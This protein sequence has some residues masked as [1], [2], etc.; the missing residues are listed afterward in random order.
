MQS[1]KMTK[2][3]KT[4][5][6]TEFFEMID[7]TQPIRCAY[8]LINWQVVLLPCSDFQVPSDARQTRRRCFD[9]SWARVALQ[10]ID[11]SESRKERKAGPIR[12][13][14]RKL[15]GKLL[16]GDWVTTLDLHIWLTQQT[17]RNA[18]TDTEHQNVSVC[19]IWLAR[20]NFCGAIAMCSIL[21]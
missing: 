13:Q 11:Q 12:S 2:L 10:F 18:D 3:L 20:S 1:S 21:T 5:S 8:Q 14:E 16:A 9:F 6:Y 15:A 4:W 19:D 7:L 17:H